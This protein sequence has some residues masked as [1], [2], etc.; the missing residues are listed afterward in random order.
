[1]ESTRR[2]QFNLHRYLVLTSKGCGDFRTGMASGRKTWS[3][4]LSRSTACRLKY[5]RARVPGCAPCSSLPLPS[6]HSSLWLSALGTRYLPPCVMQ[7]FSCPP[8]SPPHSLLRTPSIYPYEGIPRPMFQTSADLRA[9]QKLSGS[10]MDIV[11]P[12]NRS[13]SELDKQLLYRPST[14]CAVHYLL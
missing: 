10:S 4:M 14:R 8:W 6:L 3:D 5:R 13:S 9:S 11:S 12:R 2:V 1:M 7:S